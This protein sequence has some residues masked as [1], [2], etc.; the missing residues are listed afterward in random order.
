MFDALFNQLLEDQ[1]AL[2]EARSPKSEPT[3]E[4]EKENEK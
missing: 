3:N 4:S 2:A 1:R